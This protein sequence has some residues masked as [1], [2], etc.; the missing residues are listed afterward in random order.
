MAHNP[1]KLFDIKD[2]GYIKKGY[3]ADIVLINSNK[4]THITKES[5]FSK[6]GWSPFEGE[7]FD[8]EIVATYLNGEKVYQNGSIS[9]VKFGVKI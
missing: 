3:F 6:C 8:N 5:L 7:T 9:D 4:K 1:A 2:R